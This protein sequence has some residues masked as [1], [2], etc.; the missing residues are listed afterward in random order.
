MCGWLVVGW[1][2]FVWD[3]SDCLP[4]A[5]CCGGPYGLVH[6][7]TN[8]DVGFLWSYF[9]FSYLPSCNSSYVSLFLCLSDEGGGISGGERKRLGVYVC[10]CVCVC[11]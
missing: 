7:L 5:K 2:V 3:Y 9:V 6:V 4:D 8:V 11:V 1:L 10:V